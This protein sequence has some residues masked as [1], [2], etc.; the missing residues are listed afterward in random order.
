MNAMSHQGH[1]HADV[2]SQGNAPIVPNVVAKGA[3]FPE[4]DQGATDAQI[5]DAWD[6]QDCREDGG[7]ALHDYFS[8]TGRTRPNRMPIVL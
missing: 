8:A 7:D 1:P 6:R 3:P 4:K 5:E 2:D